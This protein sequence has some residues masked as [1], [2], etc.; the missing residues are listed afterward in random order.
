MS[1]II[2]R[3]QSSTPKFFKILR[4]IGVTLAAVSGL[5]RLVGIDYLYFHKT[6]HNEKN[7]AAG[8]FPVPAS[9]TFRT[10]N[11]KTAATR[12]KLDGHYG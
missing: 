4:N 7:A 6:H 12:Q 1:N 11:A 9:F 3:M 8:S 10:T 2:N 5:S